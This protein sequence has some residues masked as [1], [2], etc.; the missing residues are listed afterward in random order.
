MTARWTK[1]TGSARM[2]AA[3]ERCSTQDCLIGLETLGFRNIV[4]LF[5]LK[6][7][8]ALSREAVRPGR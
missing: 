6:T 1:S 8:R 3:E 4:S 5:A 7:A 2:G